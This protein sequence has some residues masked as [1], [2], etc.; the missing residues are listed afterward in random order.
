MTAP[1]TP[2]AARLDRI[3]AQAQRD[4]AQRER[5][6]REQALKLFP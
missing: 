1:K 3:I 4:R 6:Y 2:D 5:G